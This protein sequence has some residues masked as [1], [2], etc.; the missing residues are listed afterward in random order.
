MKDLV[1][2]LKPV[3]LQLLP[4]SRIHQRLHHRQIYLPP[5]RFQQR[6]RHRKQQQLKLTSR[7]WNQLLNLLLWKAIFLILQVIF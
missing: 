5:Q 2:I 6:Q 3:D 7:H 4:L 1:M